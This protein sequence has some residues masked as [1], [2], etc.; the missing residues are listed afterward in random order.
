MADGTLTVSTIKRRRLRFDNA[1]QTEIAHQ[2]NANT[3]EDFIAKVTYFPG[4]RNGS[5]L[6]AT[7]TQRTA[8]DRYSSSIPQLQVNLVLPR[9]SLVFQLVREGRLAEFKAL[10]RDGKASLRDHD[11]LGNSLLAVSPNPTLEALFSL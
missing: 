11:D 5:M 8:R 6:K 9:N 2:K 10:L 7:I 1:E 3:I 4:S